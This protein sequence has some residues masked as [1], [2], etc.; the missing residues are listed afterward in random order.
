MKKDHLQKGYHYQQ[1]G[2]NAKAIQE[3]AQVQSSEDAYEL[4][5]CGLAY[6]YVLTSLYHDAVRVCQDLIA[7]RS[8]EALCRSLWLEF[9]DENPFLLG[10]YALVKLGNLRA[11]G[12][13]LD[14]FHQAHA[15]VLGEFF[16]KCVGC[17]WW[18]LIRD[19]GTASTLIT[20]WQASGLQ[21]D[22]PNHRSLLERIAALKSRIDSLGEVASR[23]RQEGI[24]PKAARA[25]NDE[26]IESPT[27][28]HEEARGRNT[29]S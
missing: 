11:A 28:D 26:V 7:C 16:E 2:K 15:P 20:A 27:T 10:A 4:A 6:C 19:S 3:Y 17:E 21:A 13:M 24:G 23:L 9:V 14:A 5:R 12:A 18:K 29:P 8:S 22:K 25:S 1:C